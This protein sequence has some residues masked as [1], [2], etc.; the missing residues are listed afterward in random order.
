[1][2]YEF[3]LQHDVGVSAKRLREAAAAETAVA[4]EGDDNTTS[5][6]AGRGV[7]TI[8]AVFSA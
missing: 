5:G 6:P 8:L 7:K 3:N 1:M 2:N 4:H